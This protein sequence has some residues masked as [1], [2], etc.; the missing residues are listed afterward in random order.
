MLQVSREILEHLP[1]AVI[2][3][4]D[5]GLIVMANRQANRLLTSDDGIPLLSCEAS[6]RLPAAALAV[7]ADPDGRERRIVLTGG[8][9]AWAL[10]RTMGADSVSRGRILM[11]WPESGQENS[12]P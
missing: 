6:L 7:L 9:S 2:G 10:C 1:T 4:D 5:D 3:I 8:L 12:R 11:L